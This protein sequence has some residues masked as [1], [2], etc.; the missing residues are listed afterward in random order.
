LW[1]QYQEHK[2]Q[3]KAQRAEAYSQ[4]KTARETYTQQLMGWYHQR[5]ESLNRNSKLTAKAKRKLR[6][7]LY[8]EQKADFAKRR[9]QEA[10]Q[11]QGIRQKYPN[12][13]WEQWLIQQANQGHES[14]LS[15]L[16]RRERVRQRLTQELLTVKSLEEAKVIIYPQLKPKTRKN[17]DVIYRLKDGGL[18]ED[19]AKAV[20]VPE[21]TEAAVL[22]ALTL[23]QE[24]FP[25]QP[26][27]ING[28]TDF[29]SKIAQMTVTKGM[30]LRFDA[31]EIEHERQKKD[32]LQKAKDA[33][34]KRESPGFKQDRGQ[35]RI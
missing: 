31:K 32:E 10:E 19:T 30:N 9:G 3:L 16:R 11:R 26:L 18:V 20:F 15:L 6:Q 13:T 14:A 5:H 22:L 7:Q 25:G 23:A 2:V 24:R 27:I 29:K 35:D 12:L 4:L 8:N 17:G 33:D 1:K 28:S 34:G 21:V